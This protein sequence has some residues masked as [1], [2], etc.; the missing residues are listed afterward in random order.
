MSAGRRLRDAVPECQLPPDFDQHVYSAQL[1]AAIIAE[2]GRQQV[3]ST[4]A[5]AGTGLTEDQLEAHTTRISYRQIDIVVRNALRLSNEPTVALRAGQRMRVTAHGMYG[6]ALLSS[7]TYH[8]ARAFANRYLRVVGPLCDAKYSYDGA[9]VVC[10]FEPLHWPNPTQDV[11][12]FA[13]EFALSSHLT[14]MKDL[15]GESF[16]FSQIS[17]AYGEPAHASAYQ[18]IFDCPVLFR[19]RGNEYRYQLSQ[20]DGP[21]ALADS[22][23]HGM[24]RE[25]CEQVLSEVNHAGG[26]A[27]DVRRVLIEQ[28]GRYP[29]IEAIAERLSM[30]PRALRRKLEAEDTSYRELLAEVR[31]RLAIEYLRKTAMTNEEIASR[32]GYSDA[33][34]FRH[35]F[36]RWT[37]KSPS[38]FR[39]SS[40]M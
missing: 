19:Q 12:R 29:N 10:A 34:N 37:G 3:R 22:R 40:P 26:I 6:Y 5:L 8:D 36:I 25:M 7:A 18:V 39:V 35:A 28:P 30:H 20:A 11:H 38:D 13:A 16:R 2:L 32:L 23:T 24:A 31:T 27:A 9:A 33:A 14:T 17:L 1:I 15:A 4:V 21:V